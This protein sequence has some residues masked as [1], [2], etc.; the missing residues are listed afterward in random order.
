MSTLIIYATKYGCTEKCAKMLSEKLQGKVELWNLKENKTIDFTQYDK[1]ILGGS[2]HMGKIQKE[3]TELCSKNLNQL[4]D[5]KL[6]LFI[7]CMREG[8]TAETELNS[9]FP[10][11]LLD[12]AVATGCFGGE[13]IFKKMNFIDKMI[14][15]KVA[16]TNKDTSAI[17]EE[18]IYRFGQSMNNA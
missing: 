12:H 1:I 10:Q 18:S 11:K 3:V 16:N 14:I 8:D 6:G 17:S 9:S 7:C 4:K 5:K 13:F 15:K 2:I